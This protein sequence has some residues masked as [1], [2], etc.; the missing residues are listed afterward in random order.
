MEER[1]VEEGMRVVRCGLYMAA[2]KRP[3]FD[4]F[5]AEARMVAK[6]IDYRG[7]SL[8]RGDMILIPTALHGLDERENEDP[9]A[10]DFHRRNIAHQTFGGGPHR[11]VGLHLARLEVMVTLQEWLKRIPAF[12]LGDEGRP[13]F[14]SGIIAAVENV[15]LHWDVQ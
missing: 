14:H 15:P 12:R 8:K 6:D 5:V 11:C 2:K 1:A 7:I 9:L 4:A 10:V 3:K 13:V